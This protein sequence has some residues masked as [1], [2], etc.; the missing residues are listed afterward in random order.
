MESNDGIRTLLEEIRDVERDHLAEY[1][2]VTERSLSLQE[3][4]V[5]RQEQAAKLY[6][7]VVTLSAVLISAL[8]LAVFVYLGLMLWPR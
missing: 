4:A 8:V 7:R 6:R 1:R 5:A 3:A 2:R